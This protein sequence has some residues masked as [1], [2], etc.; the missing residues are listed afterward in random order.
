VSGKVDDLETGDAITFREGA[1]DLHRSGI[2][3][4]VGGAI[5]PPGI[6]HRDLAERLVVDPAVPLGVGDFVGVAPD[7]HTEPG[8]GAAVIDVAV[9]EYNPG[10]PSELRRSF[11]DPARHHLRAG[12]ESENPGA[13][14]LGHQVDVHPPL[15]V[16]GMTPDAF[17]DLFGQGSQWVAAG[18][19]HRLQSCRYAR[20]RALSSRATSRP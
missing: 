10:Q 8:R 15:H 12:I 18:F 11:A 19:G 14:F 4:R 20:H 13:V 16:T 2:P 3:D 7:R 5:K 17:S 6:G 1:T 9:P